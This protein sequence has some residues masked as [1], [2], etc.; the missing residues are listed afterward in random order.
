MYRLSYIVIILCP[1][2]YLALFDELGETDL[3]LSVYSH[4]SYL[5]YHQPHLRTFRFLRELHLWSAV[6]SGLILNHSG[7]TVWVD[8]E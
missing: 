3:N 8:D 5:G 7:V 4:L 2:L 1:I 6:A